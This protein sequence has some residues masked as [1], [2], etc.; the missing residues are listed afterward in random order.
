MKM[1]LF[2]CIK[3]QPHNFIAIRIVETIEGISGDATININVNFLGFLLELFF[4]ERSMQ[5]LSRRLPLL[6]HLNGDL[7]V[8]KSP[9]VHEWGTLKEVTVNTRQATP[10]LPFS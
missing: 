4:A 1:I 8:Q 10:A 6:P 3:F 9:F 2:S 7:W 5:C